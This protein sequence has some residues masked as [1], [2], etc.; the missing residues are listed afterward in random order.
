MFKS[1][2]ILGCELAN[3]KQLHGLPQTEVDALRGIEEVSSKDKDHT[4]KSLFS[5]DSRSEQALKPTWDS[6]LCLDAVNLNERRLTCID[7]KH[8]VEEKLRE[9]TKGVH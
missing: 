5:K 6:R 7:L 3:I 8:K 9:I 4:I 2:K 1:L